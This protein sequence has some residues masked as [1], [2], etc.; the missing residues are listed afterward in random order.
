M[1]LRVSCT[2]VLYHLKHSLV[3]FGHF[4]AW[5]T[6]RSPRTPRMRTS[7]CRHV[8]CHLTNDP[9]SR[10][11]SWKNNPETRFSRSKHSAMHCLCNGILHLVRLWM[12]CVSLFSKCLYI[13][14]ILQQTRC[15]TLYCG[16]VR[17]ELSLSRL[18]YTV[19]H[20]F[21]GKMKIVEEPNTFGYVKQKPIRQSD[22]PFDISSFLTDFLCVQVEQSLSGSGKQTTT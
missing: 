6:R 15:A 22:L 7:Y 3:V 9:K 8:T 13:N 2:A 12:V 21:A 16:G 20:G 4:V 19:N 11:C 1:S 18:F 17:F 10:K 5:K 14:W